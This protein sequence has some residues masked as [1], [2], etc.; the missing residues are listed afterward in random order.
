MNGTFDAVPEPA[1]FALLGLGAAALL[2]R[3]RRA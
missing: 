3:R 1:P 2:R